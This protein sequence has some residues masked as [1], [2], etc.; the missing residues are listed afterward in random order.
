MG[1]FVAV[2][3][4]N[5]RLVLVMLFASLAV[6]A[7]AMNSLRGKPSVVLIVDASESTYLPGSAF[8]STVLAALTRLSDPALDLTLSVVKMC[9]TASILSLGEPMTPTL[10]REIVKRLDTPCD[11]KGT[12]ISKGLY[13]TASIINKVNS[14]RTGIL[15]V[16]DGV[17]NDDPTKTPTYTI[18]SKALLIDPRVSWMLVAGVKAPRVQEVRENFGTIT[19]KPIRPF[20]VVSTAATMPRLED[21]L[22]F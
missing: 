10:M 6:A 8:R 2:L 16:T 4:K 19:S 20:H 3:N 18:T 13:L 22:R 9:D 5:L 17:F 21:L 12:A 15:L 1:K 7:F 11:Q 14:K